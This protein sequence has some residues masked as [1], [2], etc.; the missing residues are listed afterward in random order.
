MSAVF[1]WLILKSRMLLQRRG[2][3]SFLSHAQGFVQM[4]WYGYLYFKQQFVIK[5]LVAEEVLITNLHK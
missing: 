5:F 1:L 3:I 2:K 4:A